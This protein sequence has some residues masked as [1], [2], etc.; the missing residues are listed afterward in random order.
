ME[1]RVEV[2]LRRRFEGGRDSLPVRRLVE[3]AL[4]KV[5]P[6]PLDRGLAF[7]VADPLGDVLVRAAHSVSRSPAASADEAAGCSSGSCRSS[8]A[9]AKAGCSHFSGATKGAGRGYVSYPFLS[10]VTPLCCHSTGIGGPHAHPP[11]PCASL[12]RPGQ[13]AVRRCGWPPTWHRGSRVRSST[14]TVAPTS[15]DAVPHGSDLNP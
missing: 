4:V 10:V 7:G 14:S 15:R 5:H 8:G 1:Q 6:Q 3:P 9:A 11:I 2:V 12:S 13:Q